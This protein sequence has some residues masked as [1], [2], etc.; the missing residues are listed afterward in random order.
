M[1]RRTP[2][3]KPSCPPPHFLSTPS[4]TPCPPE[5]DDFK[6]VESNNDNRPVGGS[7]TVQGPVKIGPLFSE[8]S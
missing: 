3:L 5:L 1:G 8:E 7:V 2:H 6:R 4:Y